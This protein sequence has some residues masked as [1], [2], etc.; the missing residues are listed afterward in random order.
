MLPAEQKPPV[1]LNAPTMEKYR[2]AMRAHYVKE[3][4]VFS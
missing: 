4:P 2:E 3:K 1:S